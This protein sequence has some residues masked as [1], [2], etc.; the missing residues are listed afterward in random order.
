MHEV[1]VTYFPLNNSVSTVL[2]ANGLPMWT[3]MDIECW[4]VVD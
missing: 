3:C 4:M 1:Y 2:G